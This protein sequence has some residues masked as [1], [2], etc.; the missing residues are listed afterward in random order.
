MP[1]MKGSKN[2]PKTTYIDF[3]GLTLRS[4]TKKD[5]AELKDL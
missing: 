4:T 5:K 1:R 3:R 2:R